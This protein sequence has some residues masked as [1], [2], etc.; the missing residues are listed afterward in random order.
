MIHH[1]GRLMLLLG[2]LRLLQRTARGLKITTRDLLGQRRLGQCLGGE[3]RLLDLF[4]V[5]WNGNACCKHTAGNAGDH[6]VGQFHFALQEFIA[7]QW[8]WPRRGRL[9]AQCF[10][11]LRHLMGRPLGLPIGRTRRGDIGICFGRFGVAARLIVLAL[12]IR[13]LSIA[14]FVVRT[15]QVRGGITLRAAFVGLLDERAGAR[16]RFGRRRSF[17]RAG[18]QPETQQACDQVCSKYHRSSPRVVRTIQV[19][20][21]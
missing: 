10:I 19:A 4:A 5:L 11:A 8:W 18:N 12:G 21:T 13:L 1:R 20:D 2:K 3:A 6:G 15:L 16:Q 14:E 7:A 9:L 17:R